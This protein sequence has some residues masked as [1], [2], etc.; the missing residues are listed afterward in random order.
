MLRVS[1]EERLADGFR[2]AAATDLR[3]A[4][5]DHRAWCRLRRR[6]RHPMNWRCSGS[7][8]IELNAFY[9]DDPGVLAALLMNRITLHPGEAL[10]CRPETCM[11][12]SAAAG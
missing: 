3:A 1:G 10:S 11:P 2:A 4:L 12:T 9:P 6:Y 7:T 8:A 5:H